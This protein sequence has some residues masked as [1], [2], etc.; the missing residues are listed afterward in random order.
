MIEPL[1]IKQ[2]QQ[3]KCFACRKRKGKYLDESWMSGWFNKQI[4]LL[5]TKCKDKLYHQDPP[6]GDGRHW[7]IKMIRGEEDLSVKRRTTK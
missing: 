1:T 3:K 2:H 7:T 6:V 5:C 4:I